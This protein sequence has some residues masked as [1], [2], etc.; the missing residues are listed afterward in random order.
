M[1]N[2][3]AKNKKAIIRAAFLIPVFS[4]A[5][6]SIS[7]VVSWYDLANPMSWAVYLSIAV[8]VAAMS[9]IAASSVKVKGFSVWFVFSI[10][11]LIQFIGNIFF[12]YSDIN[13]TSKEFK[14]WAELT[15][16]IF[17]SMGTDI[18][19]L[20]SQR[21]WLALLEGGLL[22]LISLTCLHFFIKY[23]EIDNTEEVKETVIPESVVEDIIEPVSESIIDEP[24]IESA[25]EPIYE[26][27]AELIPESEIKME[28]PVTEH[29]AEETIPVTDENLSL[30]VKN[31]ED[32]S[33]QTRRVAEISNKMKKIINK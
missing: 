19:D 28:E 11:T 3:I 22:P 18:S 12:S 31:I 2:W 23:G 10:V 32:E 21:R 25:V 24:I 17:D 16:P 8:E 15:A 9:A 20:T 7:H 1:T 14:D 33:T 4:V 30:L 13:I 26:P 5:A 27:I 6:I 29:V